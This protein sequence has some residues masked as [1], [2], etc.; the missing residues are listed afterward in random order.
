M[1]VFL[2][3]IESYITEAAKK[4]SLD[5]KKISLLKKPQKTLQFDLI[6]KGSAG[7][8]KKFKSY[9]IQHNNN[10]GPYK[11]GIRF[12]PQ[13][14]LQ[15]INALAILM[16]LK[17]ALVNLPFGGAKGGVEVDPKQ[18]T[19]QELE[20]LSREFVRKF[21]SYLGPKKDIPAPDV[22]TNP[23][24]MAWMVD[25]YSKLAGK[26]TPAAFTGKP[27]DKNGSEGREEA[28]GFGGVVVLESFFKKIRSL[29]NQINQPPRVAIQGF[30]NVGEHI[31]Q[32]LFK[33]GYKII[34]VSDS[35]GGVFAPQGLNIPLVSKCKKEK[36]MVSHCYCIGSVCDYRGNG[37]ITNEQL[38]AL[39]TDILIPAAL[40]NAITGKNAQNIKAKIILEMANGALSFKA[41]QILF[42][43][44]VLVIPDILAN[45][46]GVIGSYL[47]WRQ[48]LTDE[49]WT[50]KEVFDKIKKIL[51]RATVQLIRA[52]KK[53]KFS[54]K[55]TAF[56]LAIDKIFKRQKSN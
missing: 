23:R 36:G 43:K 14:D 34:A 17:N 52:Q 54:L 41:E 48:N 11:G 56:I 35:R 1:N 29:K 27:L 31:A 21:F 3:S 28:T 37:K 13:T 50:K 5:K 40:E 4:L 49:R 20:S 25:E 2:K 46:G 15:E 44:N 10:L 7:Q 51:N 30:G 26:W 24:I 19:K 39:K 16:T 6:I 47:E 38:L 42:K 8:E 45:A 32:L 53:Y 18:L 12:H 9:R 22:N 55:Q 33:K